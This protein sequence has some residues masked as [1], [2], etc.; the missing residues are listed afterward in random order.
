MLSLSLD[1]PPLCGPDLPTQTPASFELSIAPAPSPC[2]NPPVGLA[3]QWLWPDVST[4]KQIHSFR[5]SE[6]IL[7]CHYR[8]CCYRSLYTCCTY[9]VVRTRDPASAA[10]RGLICRLGLRNKP[11]FQSSRRICVCLVVLNRLMTIFEYGPRGMFFSIFVAVALLNAIRSTY[12][13]HILPTP[14]TGTPTLEES[15]KAFRK[16]PI[17]PSRLTSKLSDTISLT[18]LPPLSSSHTHTSLGNSPASS[19]QCLHPLASTSAR[20]S[21]PASSM[22]RQL[23]GQHPLS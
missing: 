14:P 16:V 8:C 22:P 18:L 19:P 11:E 21:I 6:R 20:H 10:A 15:F 2:S 13:Y 3:K 4:R 1:G 7:G 23:S 9:E 17:P 5:Y 12:A